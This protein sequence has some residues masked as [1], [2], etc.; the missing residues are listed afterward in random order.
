MKPIIA[1]NEN[2]PDKEFLEEF[3]KI[4]AKSL[5]RRLGIKYSKKL[6]DLSKKENKK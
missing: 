4:L 5:V 1:V 6:I 3:H 2:N